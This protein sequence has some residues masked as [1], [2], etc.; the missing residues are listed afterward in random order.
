MIKKDCGLIVKAT[1]PG[2]CSEKIM[3]HP[4]EEW[5]VTT[6]GLYI[7]SQMEEAVREVS[8][9][10]LT[11]KR[12]LNL[13]AKK[14][15]KDIFG[16]E[17]LAGQQWLVTHHMTDS[18]LVDVHEEIVDKNVEDIILFQ[19]QYCV[20]INPVDKDSKNQWGKKLLR[21]GECQFFLQ[22]HESLENGVESV[23]FL[24]EDKA[25]LLQ[26]L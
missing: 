12:A 6:N 4:G 18:H 24:T 1:L 22:P 14:S 15:F 26:A 11:E 5:M 17:R 7:P 9:I 3:R 21:K 16:K 20:I 19:D 2:H 23:N 8:P 10:V 25:L 13:K